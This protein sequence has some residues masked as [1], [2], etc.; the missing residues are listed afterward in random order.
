MTKHT[1]QLP[2]GLFD[3]LTTVAA[4]AGQSP[5]ELILAAIEQHL[6]DVSDLRAIAEYEKQKADGTLVTIPFDEV[7]RRL[8]LDD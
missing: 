1:L 2:D 6:E 8:G 7:K 5:D 4:E 3:Y